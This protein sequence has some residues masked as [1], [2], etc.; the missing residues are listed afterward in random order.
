MS[1]RAPEQEFLEGMSIQGPDC[2]LS[3]LFSGL[4]LKQAALRDEVMSPSGTKS[5]LVCSLNSGTYMLSRY[6]FFYSS[7]ECCIVLGVVLVGT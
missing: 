3:K 7:K 4:C 5:G 6:M 1:P 2:S